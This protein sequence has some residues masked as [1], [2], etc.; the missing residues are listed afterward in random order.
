MV[1]S[2]LIRP[3]GHRLLVEALKRTAERDWDLTIPFDALTHPDLAA[4]LNRFLGRM[5]EEVSRSASAAIAVSTTAPLLADL[6]RQTR[7]DSE[8]LSSAASSIAGA[9]EQM[10][11]TVERE[12][13]DNTREL[14]A[15]STR[16]AAAVADCDGYGSE[17]HRHVLDVDTRVADLAQEIRALNADA[18]RIGEIIRLIDSIARQTNLLA[19]NAAIEAARAGEHGRGFA[20]VAEQVRNLAYQTADA[21]GL[22]QGIVADV[23]SRIAAAVTGVEQVRTGMEVERTTVTDTRAR[24]GEARASMDQ[25]DQRIRGIS[26]ATEQMGYAAQSVSRDVQDVASVAKGMS[27]KAL[28]VSD[29]GQKL[30]GLSDELLAA[31]GIFRLQAHRRAREAVES[32]AGQPVLRSLQSRE[33]QIALRKALA[34]HDFFELLYLTNESGVQISENVAP[35]GFTASYGGTG[36]GEDW[37]AREWFRYA[38]DEGITYVT[39]VYRSAATGQFC[40]T[41]A[42]PIRDRR[43]EV[44]AILGA[45]VRLAAL[46]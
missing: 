7:L 20:V 16:V 45:D 9:S 35:E 8:A 26:A 3:A 2:R 15:F 40:F 22:V 46:L 29:A 41:V 10:A 13:A 33:I 6:A 36:Y 43:G 1:L 23:Q 34:E 12:L 39:P 28:A 37:S 44:A 25:L 4:A 24:L 21:T 14:A 30:H 27:G 42:T 19:L 18:E 38:R 32:V 5:A 17:M 11:C 31:I